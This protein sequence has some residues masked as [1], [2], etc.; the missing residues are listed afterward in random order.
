[1]IEKVNPAHPDKV[2]D[3]IAGAIVDLAYKKNNNPKLY[4]IDLDS[5]FNK[6]YLKDDSNLNVD[7][8]KDIRFSKTTLLHIKDHKIDDSSDDL[9]DI[10]EILEDLASKVSSDSSNTQN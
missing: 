4:T 9:S 7:D 2:A 6:K 8:I 10:T 1:M 3:R 5:A